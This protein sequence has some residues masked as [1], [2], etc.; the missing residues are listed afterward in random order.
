MLIASGCSGGSSSGD[1]AE[2]QLCGGAI[3]SAAESALQSMMGSSELSFKVGSSS[4]SPKELKEKALEWGTEENPE[5]SA[6]NWS[7]SVS[8]SGSGAA[9][10][11]ASVST[12]WS[13]LKTSDI[14]REVK[15]GSKEYLEVSPGVFIGRNSIDAPTVFFPCQVAQDGKKSAT[16]TLGTSVETH[17]FKSKG[18]TSDAHRVVL[19][20]ARWISDEVG[21]VNDPAIPVSA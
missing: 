10:S 7:C 11:R 3:T 1:S 9:E 4:S 8:S 18:T 19:S 15:G 13:V 6:V 17:F 20:A 5:P 2:Q 14:S 21:C 16:Y 12:L